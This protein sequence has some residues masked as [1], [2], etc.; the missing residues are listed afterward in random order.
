MPLRRRT[1]LSSRPPPGPGRNEEPATA[2]SKSRAPPGSALTNGQLID[3][4]AAALNLT[5][6]RKKSLAGKICFFDS[7]DEDGNGGMWSPEDDYVSG[8]RL[9]RNHTLPD[10]PNH[11][12]RDW[13]L[14][15]I[16]E[17]ENEENEAAALDEG[18]RQTARRA[19]F[20]D[21]TADQLSEYSQVLAKKREDDACAFRDKNCIPEDDATPEQIHK[22]NLKRIML[23]YGFEHERQA[24]AVLKLHEAVTTVDTTIDL[25]HRVRPGA[26]RN[27]EKFPPLRRSVLFPGALR[28]GSSGFGPR[29]SCPHLCR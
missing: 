27:Y 17:K 8:G 26:V 18:Q 13:L 1:A 16:D 4:F 29:P 6:D 24:E 19:L 3:I 5:P 28:E 14:E 23:N 7:T 21:L 25:T 12:V 15:V 22:C 10:V 2:F 11:F 9:G 20:P